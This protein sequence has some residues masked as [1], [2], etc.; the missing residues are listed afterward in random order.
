MTGRTWLPWLA[1][2]LIMIGQLNYLPD[3]LAFLRRTWTFIGLPEP[4]AARLAYGAADYDLLVWLEQHT[5]PET[6]IL[7]VTASPQTYGDP[8][9]VLYHRA[10]YHLYPRSVWWA[11]PVPAN[12][13][14]AWWTFTDLS[15]AHLLSL[16][17]QY[18]ATVILADGFAEEPV[19]GARLS[20]DDDTHLI[21]LD[22]AK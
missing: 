12:R 19:P 8:S 9:Y 17:E 20:F 7:L 22:E 13:H 4:A 1:L 11:A 15:P 3:R 6:T 10:L 14:P 16:A 18:Q 2:L 21:L 5:L